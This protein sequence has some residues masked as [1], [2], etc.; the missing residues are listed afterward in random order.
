MFRPLQ[1]TSLQRPNPAV[2]PLREAS[3][4]FLSLSILTPSKRTM[5]R[6]NSRVRGKKVF[7]LPVHLDPGPLRLSV[8]GPL[9]FFSGYL[10]CR[11]SAQCAG[12]CTR[13]DD[14]CENTVLL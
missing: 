14:C 1:P 10:W 7:L 5:G 4:F 3:F 11:L 2:P 6:F 8:L 13:C 9:C 12:R